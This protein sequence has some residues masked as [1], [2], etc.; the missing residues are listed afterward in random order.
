M[1]H[2]VTEEESAE[3]GGAWG[4]RMI[5]HQIRSLGNKGNF[6][7]CF[8]FVFLRP[9]VVLH[10]FNTRTWESGRQL[11]VNSRLACLLYIASSR[12]GRDT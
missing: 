8:D 4:L 7:V 10:S 5:R 11:S 3:G 9:G 6:K 2:S 1:L 12:T